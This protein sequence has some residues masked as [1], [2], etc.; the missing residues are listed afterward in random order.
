MQV[1]F[2]RLLALERSFA[3]GVGNQVNLYY[4]DLSGATD[5][6][7]IESLAQEHSATV[8]TAE[9]S[10][11]LDLS[12]LGEIVGDPGAPFE[13]PMPMMDGGPPPYL[14]EGMYFDGAP[15]CGN[16]CGPASTT[17]T[18]SRRMPSAPRPAQP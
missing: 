8:V 4:A 5:V 10:L 14:S 17:S 1:L 13:G 7:S 12:T 9:K 16:C 15:Y 11:A 18:S 6:R 2:G 3:A